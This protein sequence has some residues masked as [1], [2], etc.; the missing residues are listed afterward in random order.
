MSNL[1]RLRGVAGILAGTA[2]AW[3][4]DCLT[5]IFPAAGLSRHGRAD[6]F[7]HTV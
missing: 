6:I 7:R 5:V 1:R 4:A 2:T 3:P